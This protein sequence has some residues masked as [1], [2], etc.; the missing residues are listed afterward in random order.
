MTIFPFFPEALSISSKF[1]HHYQRDN[2]FR[3]HCNQKSH[4]KHPP[5]K[6]SGAITA[7]ETAI[8]IAVFTFVQGVLW[9]PLLRQL[10]YKKI[11]LV[12]FGHDEHNPSSRLYIR[13]IKQYNTLTI[14]ATAWAP[15]S[16]LLWLAQWIELIQSK[17]FTLSLQFGHHEDVRGCRRRLF[18]CFV[19]FFFYYILLTSLS[20]ASRCSEVCF[21]SAVKL[22]GPWHSRGFTSDPGSLKSLQCAA[23]GIDGRGWVDRRSVARSSD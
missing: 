9:H 14:R 12:Y 21:W 22:C 7:T 8:L 15:F 20:S 19:S 5:P 6:A 11:Q 1:Y 17:L 10:I 13:L 18:P 23:A 2:S 16:E 3:N 4:L